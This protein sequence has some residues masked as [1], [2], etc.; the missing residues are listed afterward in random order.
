MN[1]VTEKEKVSFKLSKYIIPSIVSMVVV[2][3]N[4]NIDGFFIGNILGDAGLAAINIAWPIVAVICSLGTGIGIGGSVLLN[5]MRGLG[6]EEDAERVKNLTLILLLLFGIISGAVFSLLAEPL[7]SL[8]GAEGEVLLHSLEYSRVIS[9]GAV[10]Q[11]L[12]AGLVVLLRNDKRTYT[13]MVYSLI[14]LVLH[15][16]LDVVLARPLGMTGLALATV[17]SQGVI[18]ILAIISLGVNVRAMPRISHLP[19]VL[20]N[21]IA[22][23]GINFVPS[24]V[25]LFTNAAAL[26]SGGVA[27]VS[28][29]AAMSY[30]VYTFDYIFQGISDGIQ[31]VVSYCRGSGDLAQERRAV[32]SAAVISGVFSVVC[33][34]LTPLLIIVL[35]SALG[36]SGEAAEII[37]TAF[38]I[39]AVSYPPKAFVKFISSYLYSS[40]RQ[41]LSSILVYI[42]PLILTPV[43][44]LLLTKAFGGVGVWISMPLSQILISVI[45]A[46]ALLIMTKKKAR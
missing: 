18:F 20:V 21:S 31:P 24:L 35:P 38:W 27:A 6:G 15:I 10:A 40:N 14:G 4:A 45:G 7:L 11:V 12:G 29:Y 2:G 30:A 23:F 42:D 36:A 9:A 17:V 13:S 41:L 25:L 19:S 43:S 5:R 16:A 46:A 33:V 22:P 34:L 1:R 26:A 39:Y 32:R 37:K 3:T 44:L 8:M 28:A